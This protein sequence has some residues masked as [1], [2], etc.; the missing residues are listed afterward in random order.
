[1]SELLSDLLG[2]IFQKELLKLGNQSISLLWLIELF[3]AVLAVGI[4]TRLLK[5]LLKYRVLGKFGIDSG[6]KE[7]IATLISLGVGT[8][9]YLIVLQVSGLDLSSVAVII[10]GLG[11]GIGF[12][13]QDITKNLLSGL[14]VLFERKL[15]VGDFIEF[16]GIA[17]FIEEID[18]RSTVIRTLEGGEVIIPNSQL[19]EERITNWN[20]R[21]C[22]G[23]LSIDVGVAYETDPVLVTETLLEAAYSL[24]SVL[25][26]PPPKVIFDGFGDSALNFKLHFWISRIDRRAP[27]QSEVTFAVEYYLRRQGISIPFP[28]L[29]LWTRSP[30]ELTSSLPKTLV[31]DITKSNLAKPINSEN[32]EMTHPNPKPASSESLKATLSQMPYFQGF[33]ELQIRSLIEMGFRQRIERDEIVVQQGEIVREVC[34]ILSG[35]IAAFHIGKSTE[36]HIHTFKA[37]EYFGE[38]PLLL[39]VPA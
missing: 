14:T 28:Q 2:P 18:I 17:G 8:F 35:E 23:R 12:G 37:G 25:R 34:I 11:V 30:N 38:L 39:D 10:G 9:G 1:M 31:E 26:D 16:D 21:D 20:Y 29:D 4:V 32:G 6:N 19:A 13:L 22:K 15:K 27:I 33:N 3:V 24:S 36:R 7:A 5:K